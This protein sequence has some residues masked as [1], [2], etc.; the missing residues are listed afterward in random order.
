MALRIFV[1]RLSSSV[2]CGLGLLPCPCLVLLGL[3]PHIQ[4]D[5]LGSRLDTSY[6]QVPVPYLLGT[7]HPRNEEVFLSGISLQPQIRYQML[8]L[9]TWSYHHFVKDRKS[10]RL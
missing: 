2:S 8:A 5:K 9:Q 7:S 6:R 3:C 10:T 1:H 4:A